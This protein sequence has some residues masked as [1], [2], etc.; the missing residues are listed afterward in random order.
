VSIRI[1]T[2]NG[3]RVALCAARSVEKPG[4]VYL[5]DGDHHAL[6]EKFRRDFSEEGFHGPYYPEQTAA[7][8]AEESNNPA[9]SW[10][11]RIYGAEAEA[12]R[13][14]ELGR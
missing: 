1:R 8:D 11:D 2:V 9:R 12:V 14:M 4:D 10:W 13:R 6:A 3:V 5:D 7:T